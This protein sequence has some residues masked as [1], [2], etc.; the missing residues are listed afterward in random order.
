MGRADHSAPS[1]ANTVHRQILDGNCEHIAEKLVSSKPSRFVS[2][3][4]LL[5]HPSIFP[6]VR[7]S[8]DLSLAYRT[9]AFLRLSRLS[10]SSRCQWTIEVD[11]DCRTLRFPFHTHV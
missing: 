5:H 10:A 7:P 3:P 11:C 1:V 2:F 6:I 4:P 9:P 8:S